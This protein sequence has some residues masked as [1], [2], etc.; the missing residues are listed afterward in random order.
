VIPAAVVPGE[1][2]FNADGLPWSAL[3]DDIYH[4]ASGPFVQARHVFV[5]GCRLVERWRGRERFTVLETGFGLGHNFLATWDA[6]RQD[7]QRT[8]RLHF[9]SVELHPLRRDDLARAHR[10]S[11]LGELAE[12]LNGAWPSLTPDLHRLVFDGGRVQLTL[13]F[14]DARHWLR[15]LV[16]H[17]DALFLDG[18]APARN[19]Q[20]WEPRVLQSLSRLAAPG[21]TLATWTAARAVRE[22]LAKVGFQVTLAQGKGG[23]R[24]ITLAQFTPRFT[25][26]PAP[27][28]ALPQGR[29]R[30]IAIVGGGLAGCATARALA[31][32]GLSSVVLDRHADPAQGASGNPAGMFHPIVN[33]QDG[34]H[35]R[36]NR[37]AV[38]AV[39][40]AVVHAV[41]AHGVHGDTNGLL[42][43]HADP[44]GLAGMQGVLQRLG[45]PTDVVRACSAAEASALCGI[46]LPSPAWFFP[47]GGW[48]DPAGLSRS[49]LARAGALTQWRGGVAVDALRRADTGWELLDAAGVV[50]AQA[51]TVVLAN[52]GDALRLL[53]MPGWPIDQVRGQISLLSTGDLPPGF[54][55]PTL[56]VGGAG[57]LLPE[58]GAWALFG[59]TAQ[60]GDCD[61]D[62]RLA[63]HAE[64]LARLATLTGAPVAIDITRLH[65]RT[66]WR[67]SSAD[68]LPVVGAVPDAD[69]LAHIGRSSS[70]WDQPRFVPRRPGLF[71]HAGLGSRGI[72]W[73]ALGGQVLAAAICGAPAP[74]EAALLDAIDPARFVSR[75]LRRQAA[76]AA[77]SSAAQGAG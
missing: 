53:G 14:G 46:A 67:C 56:P 28:R 39:R 26:M 13:A 32:Q 33:A 5:G 55:L 45:L 62:V 73:S 17:A 48:V 42:R 21:A 15:Q 60:A 12:L 1:L 65:G 63:D 4:P 49:H 3:Y 37:A 76:D 74:L 6:W 11:E 61:A 29:D 75:A 2:A 20:M 8:E 47:G 50:L 59:A 23:K 34:S 72:A 69:A 71:V 40:E 52:A 44:A 57:Y 10:G 70:R 27:G 54:V 7:P 30:R 58:V 22:G 38:F 25:A 31:E 9:V 77:Q 68:R 24:D 16:L 36:F 51:D 66:A 19:P 64:N 43:L 41:A 35:A 18:F